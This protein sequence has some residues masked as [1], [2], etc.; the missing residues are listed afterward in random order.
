M[1]YLSVV[2]VGLRL[3]M[4]IV[5]GY[6]LLKVKVIDMDVVNAGNRYL[7]SI[8]Y[9]LLAF[10][11]I[12]KNKL[13]EISFIPFFIGGL[14]VVTMY[15][16]CAVVFIF[17]RIK[18]KFYYWLSSL[19]PCTYT[20]YLIIGLPIF[21]QIWDEGDVMV[22]VI[23]LSNDII[24]VPIFL[25]LSNIYNLKVRNEKKG[26]SQDDE[27]E[28]FSFK[29]LLH[30]L[31]RVIK[32]PIIIANVCGLIWSSIGLDMPTF[33]NRIVNI[34]A[35]GVLSYSLV[36]VGGFLS[37][38]AVISC[39]Y[40]QFFICVF[41][42]HCYTSLLAG[43]YCYILNVDKLL[44]RQCMLMT[45]MPSAAAAFILTMDA[46]CG[47][48]VSSTVIL[49]SILLCIPAVIMWS[50]VLDVLKIYKV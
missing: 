36:T 48:G 45:C 22:S 26:S 13:R 41:L 24:S 33:P 9:P 14:M 4:P 30:I 44:S 20:N 32:N 49:F 11:A 16:T 42:R 35:D 3:F 23:N 18:D 29:I 43:L 28:K 6:I 25:I 21:N 38:F 19:L 17:P 47:P 40:I 12:S 7:L 46:N 1:D 37:Q 10:R 39:P 5:I 34:I 27:Q 31:L 8:G 15:A 2:Q 50:A